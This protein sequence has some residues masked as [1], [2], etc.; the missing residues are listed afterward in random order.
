V[1]KKSRKK[2]KEPKT[3]WKIPDALWEKVKPLLD[4]AYPAKP[5]GRPR[6]D[7]RGVLDAI[8]F[9]LRSGCQWNRLPQELADD[10]TAHRWFQRWCE[11]GMFERLWSVLLAECEELGGVDWQWQSADASM[12]KARF[13]GRK[14]A[15][16]Q[17]IGRKRGQRKASS[18]R[19]VEG[20]WA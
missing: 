16:I 1:A 8:V 12:G 5:T 9:R 11:D 4:A 3:I 13:G 15:P 20:H 17:Q 19:P 14:S 18:S 7:L 10:S 2:P 6:A